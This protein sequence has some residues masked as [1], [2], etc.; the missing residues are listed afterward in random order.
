[1]ADQVFSHLLA[2]EEHRE[3]VIKSLLSLIEQYCSWIA[4]QNTLESGITWSNEA[5]YRVCVC[6]CVC[7]TGN[8]YIDFTRFTKIYTW[9][10]AITSKDFRPAIRW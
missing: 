8:N 6:V 10:P 5:W 3:V 4:N 2:I 9:L 1:M 7:T